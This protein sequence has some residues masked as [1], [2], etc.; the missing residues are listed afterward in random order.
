[1]GRFKWSVN[2]TDC[3]WHDWHHNTLYLD[4][5]TESLTWSLANSRLV[6]QVHIIVRC[7]DTQLTRFCTAEPN[8]HRSSVLN[9]FYVS[10]LAPWVSRQL[11]VFGNFVGPLAYTTPLDARPEKIQLETV[12]HLHNLQFKHLF[13][14]KVY[15]LKLD[16][17]ESRLM[18]TVWK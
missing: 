13:L 1:M 11:R 5:L 10:C 7:K 17:L 8:I 6:K 15:F 3:T 18:S 9:L 12:L 4:P 2:A 14:S 16:K